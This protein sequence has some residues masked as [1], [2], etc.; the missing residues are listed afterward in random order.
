M[1]KFKNVLI[2]VL[3]LAITVSFFSYDLVLADGTDTVKGKVEKLLY[4]SNKQDSQNRYKNVVVKITSGSHKGEEV[5]VENI[6]NETTKAQGMVGTGSNVLLHI[7]EGKD[8]KIKDAYIYEIMRSNDLMWL[9][10]VFALFLVLVGGKKGLKS[11][12]TLGL[13]AIAVIKILIPLILMGFNPIIVTVIICISV[14]IISIIILCGKNKKAL[15]AIIGT[16][17][18]LLIAGLIAMM[19]THRMALK[20]LGD[21]ESQMLIYATHNPDFNFSGL[22]FSGILL[23]AL[24]AVMDVSISIASSMFEIVNVNKDISGL[25]L[26]KSGMNVGRDIMGSMANT[27]ILAYAG[28][29]MYTLLLTSSYGMSLS[30]IINQDVVASELL[31]A[32]SGSIGLIF[33]IPLT[34]AAAGI[35]LKPSLIKLPRIM[36]RNA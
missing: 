29:A 14:I 26:I 1:K 30:K 21:E 22:L 12:L 11:V 4:D 16:A 31:K 3:L 28:S 9:T 18:G 8:G 2:L 19:M 27:L 15:S 33:T 34:A 17:G 23:G 5:T 13:T 35:L 25:G 7:D 20:G 10:I 36:N 24:G 32:L 6:V